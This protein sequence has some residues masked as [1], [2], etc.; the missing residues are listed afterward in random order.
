MVFTFF[1]VNNN[2]RFT[3]A[4]AAKALKEIVIPD[5]YEVLRSNGS[6]IPLNGN[7]PPLISLPEY[8]EPQFKAPPMQ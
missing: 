7:I 8:G 3:T 1:L 4:N 2:I 5:V 6:N